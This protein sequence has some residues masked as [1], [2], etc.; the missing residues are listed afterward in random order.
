MHRALYRVTGGRDGTD[1]SKPGRY[2]ML[3]LHTIGRRTG[4]ER[5]VIFAYYGYGARG[6]A[7]VGARDADRGRQAE[8]VLRDQ[9]ADAS[10]V[11]LDV[12]MRSRCAAPQSGS[13]P[14]ADGWTS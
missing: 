7:V 5:A 11:Q 9:K 10:F 12:T 1:L 8:R 3:R 2:G 14:S 6:M 4:K 13:R